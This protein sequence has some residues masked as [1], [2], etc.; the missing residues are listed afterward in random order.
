V[1]SIAKEITKEHSGTLGQLTS[2]LEL[3]PAF[4]QGLKHL[5]GFT[6][7]APGVRHAGDSCKSNN[8]PPEDQD[9]ARFILVTCSAFVNYIIARN[10][11]T[12][13]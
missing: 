1:E 3:H 5:Y 10:Q 4:E 6:S 7:D 2:R 8:Y 9:T 12:Q 11:A 13:D